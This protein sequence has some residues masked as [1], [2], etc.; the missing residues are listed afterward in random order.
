MKVLLILVMRGIRNE[1]AKKLA[2]NM[3]IGISIDYQKK[4]NMDKEDA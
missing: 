4:L 1:E 3:I 2:N